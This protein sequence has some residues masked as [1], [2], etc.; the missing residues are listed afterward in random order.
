MTKRRVFLGLVCLVWSSILASPAGADAPGPT[1]Y[2][3]VVLKV[4]PPASG[5]ELS[6]IGGDSFILL[7]VERGTEVVVIGYRGEPYLRVNATG[8]VEE[9]QNSPS[10]YL[11]EERYGESV[12]PAGIS[13]D[14]EPSWRQVDSDGTWAWHDH[15]TH[16]MNPQPPPGA[17]PGEQILEGVVPIFVNGAE[18]DVSVGS[19]WVAK[20]SPSAPIA[21]GL[22]GG[23]VVVLVWAKRGGIQWIALLVGS[24]AVL[25]VGAW[26]W[27]SLPPETGPSLLLW[28][29]PL[30]GILSGFVALITGSRIGP[31]GQVG[32]R[33]LASVSLALW[34]LDRKSG[35]RAAILPTQAPVAFDQFVTAAALLLGLGLTAGAIA[36]LVSP[37]K[38]L[39]QGRAL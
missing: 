35:L 22:L 30:T 2:Q 34:A 13:Y 39:R 37:T 9:N 16:W 32:L 1:D 23:L 5:V 6:M 21:G 38:V 4:D 12:V 8:I 20:P 7:K 17:E 24:V 10:K 15:R 11:N 31:V 25:V 18:V 33:L 28:L 27:T 19:F 3:S 14:S 36:V 29:L 26:Q